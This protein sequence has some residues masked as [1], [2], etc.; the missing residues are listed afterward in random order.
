MRKQ[1]QIGLLGFHI[2][3]FCAAGTDTAGG[4]LVVRAGCS[5][6]LY[7]ILAETLPLKESI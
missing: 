5:S 2:G 1:L 6:D 3:S 7:G 4:L